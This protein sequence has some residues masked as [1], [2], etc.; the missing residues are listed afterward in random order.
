MDPHAATYGS[1]QTGLIC[2]YVF[3]PQGTGRSISAE[4]ASQL[5]TRNGDEHGQEFV[6][7]HFSSANTASEKWL[8]GHLE[9]SDSFYEAMQEGS[10]STRIEYADNDLIAIV[11]D[12]MYD[13]SSEL[14]ESSE[15][16][17]L[18][19]CIDQ[20]MMVS[21]RRQPLRSIDRLRS[22][23]KNG[24]T[25][26]SPLELLVHLLRDQADVLVQIVRRAT[27]K[28]D[29]IE[30][31]LLT[32]RL[33][34]K[35]TSVGALRR[36][37]VR[38]Q[39]LLAPEPA[40]L[41]RLLSRP[42]SWFGEHDA[43]ELRQSTEEFSVVLRDMLGLQERVKLLQ[44]EIVSRVGEQTNRSVFVLTAVTVL[45]LPINIVSGLFGMNVGGVPFNQEPDGFWIVAGIVLAI[46][47]V[48]VWFVKRKANE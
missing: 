19:L 5:L 14:S 23:V 40:A 15:V 24:E 27:T 37:L 10:R 18:W 11:N 44:E 28:V 30:D 34:L 17:T 47:G 25:F 26:R 16:S 38:L 35:R 22:A 3:L 45:V 6:W 21:V 20:R 12:V 7:L 31:R 8:R 41:F 9:L 48:A 1:D 4:E 33:D 2:G 36:G 13:F 42:P 39:R 43:Q 46:T 32:G 29:G